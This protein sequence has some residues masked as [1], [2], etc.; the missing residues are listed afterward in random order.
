MRLKTIAGNWKMN[1]NYEDAKALYNAI[2]SSEL[3]I[4]RRVI[5][6]PP[7]VYLSEFSNNRNPKVFLS[8]QNCSSQQN[9]AYTGEISA[10]M[11]AS[12]NIE[13]CLVGHSERRTYFHEKETDF[14][15][16]IKQL[17]D[18]KIT[19][20]YCV[21]ETLDDRLGGKAFHVVKN[22]VQNA[23][24]EFE[25]ID[26]IILAYEPVWAIGTGHTATSEQAQEM[27]AFIRDLISKKF[28]EQ[29]ASDISILYGGSV[30]PSNAVELFTQEDIDG[31][32][33]GGA[34]LDVGSF[35]EIIKA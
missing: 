9:G 13:Y 22:Q 28:G 17:L 21:G 16:K 31:G 1:M 11:L 33:I 3:P 24:F 26:T 8:A 29:T 35:L 5:V 6:A 7:Y 2:L 4:D 30:K 25:N 12:L 19:P 10:E 27:H 15:L 18:Q 14:K 20:I 23:L 34:S 32:L